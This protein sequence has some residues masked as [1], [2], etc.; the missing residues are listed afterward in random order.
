[1]LALYRALIANPLELSAAKNSA[2]NQ[3]KIA[4]AGKKIAQ[5][6]LD[7]AKR[8]A[9]KEAVALAEAK[10]R[11][12]Q[13]NLKI[14]QAQAKRYALTSPVAGT[15]IGREVEPGETVRAGVPLLTIADTRELEMTVYVPIQKMGAIKAGQNVKLTLPSLPGKTFSGKV[16]FVASEAEFKPANL[17]NA[18]ERSEI[19]FAVRVTISNASGELKA[20]LPGDVTF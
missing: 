13:A 9:Q 10:L 17:Y 18:Q 14:T 4:E 11:A 6:E 7:I 2:A 3:V 15:V 19:V 1:M 5:A 20:G 8:G 16:S 12:A